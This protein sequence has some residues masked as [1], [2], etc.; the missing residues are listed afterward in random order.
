MTSHYDVARRLAS[1][2]TSD[3]FDRRLQGTNM[4]Y[5]PPT[6]DK[7][8][9]IQGYGWAFYALRVDDTV[10]LD[11]SWQG[12]SV[13]TTQHLT[14]IRRA[15]S[16]S[17]H[18]NLVECDIPRS[19]DTYTRTSSPTTRTRPTVTELLELLEDLHGWDPEELDRLGPLRHRPTAE[20]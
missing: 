19:V 6:G 16:R 17:D 12:Y 7:P 3:E 10:I 2:R 5:K 14:H 15:V 9:G 1:K 20:V 18:V 8:A 4:S 13:S 11:T